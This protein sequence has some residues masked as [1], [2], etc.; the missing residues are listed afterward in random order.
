MER[1]CP[2]C[3]KPLGPE[4]QKVKKKKSSKIK[5]LFCDRDLLQQKSIVSYPIN[6]RV[7]FVWQPSCRFKGN[8]YFEVRGIS[9][10]N[11]KSLIYFKSKLVQ[12]L[13]M[14]WWHC[15]QSED[16]QITVIHKSKGS[17]YRLMFSMTANENELQVT[18][19]EEGGKTDTI[20]AENT[21]K[22]HSRKVTLEEQELC[23]L[24]TNIQLDY[25]DVIKREVYIP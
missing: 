24:I 14:A 25:P 21:V 1:Q 13:K 6:D 11:M 7:K 19:F 16:H 22:D 8:V 9:K 10:I 3:Y 20:Y 15:Q 2:N 18:F 17:P 5:C 4:D 23:R 12:L